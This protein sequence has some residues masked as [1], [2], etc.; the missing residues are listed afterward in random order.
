MAKADVASLSI[1][2]VS[3]DIYPEVV[4]GL[5]LHVHNMS[6]L[7]AKWGHD[8]TVLASDQGEWSRSRREQ[9]D[10]YT[11]LFHREV[12]S[13]FNNSIVPGMARTLLE[14]IPEYD[15]VHA[16]S[17]L[18]FS[19]NL[20]A[21]LTRLDDT[22]LTI[23]NHGILSQTAPYALQRVFLPT[24]G[25]FTLNAAD[26]VFCYTEN[27]NK[28]LRRLGITTPISIIP[29]GV[30]CSVFKP[31]TDVEESQQLLYVGRLTEKKGVLELLAAFNRLQTRFE[32]LR[33]KFVGEGP[34]NPQLEELSVEWGIRNQ[35]TFEGTIRNEMLPEV[36]N[37]SSL[38]V[39]PSLN[40]GLPRTVLESLACETP[41]IVTDLAQLRSIVG[42][43]GVTTPDNEPESIAAACEHLLENDHLRD[44]LG[45]SG[46]ELVEDAH[47]WETTVRKTTEVYSRL[48]GIDDRVVPSVR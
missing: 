11:I 34:L 44:R 27:D 20:S 16:H 32:D 21:V 42:E 7:Q 28:R 45:E 22:P 38:T 8:V 12:G 30:D 39:L 18:F 3:S 40:E 15:I 31:K 17:H 24:I 4:G 5:G 2:R 25:R 43:G 10:G 19:S 35:V 48:L 26:R 23:T 9:R 13:P 14:M 33:M 37:E 29:N 6:K 46:R 1:L 41:V 36:Y 47:S